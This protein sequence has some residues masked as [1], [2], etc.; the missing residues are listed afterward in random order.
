MPS[1]QRMHGYLGN[2]DAASIR[3]RA[4]LL[5]AAF[6]GSLVDSR[7]DLPYEPLLA[8]A[9]IYQWRLEGAVVPHDAE[10]DHHNG[11]IYTSEMFAGKISKPT[12]AA[13]TR[14]I[15]HCRPTACRPAVRSRAPACRYR[16]D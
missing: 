12:S 1:V 15:S 3:K 14:C 6:D 2:A 8:T 9:R 13:V 16:M 4:E 5:A 11:N 10:Y 7:P